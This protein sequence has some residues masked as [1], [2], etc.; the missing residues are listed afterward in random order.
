M[1][2]SKQEASRRARARRP[3]PR[4]TLISAVHPNP[5]VK[6]NHGATF[7]VTDQDGAVPLS[8]GDCGL[9]SHDTRYLSRHEVRLNGRR[10]QSVASVRLSFEHARWHLIADNVEAA[11]GDMRGARVAMTVDRVLDL[12]RMHE[13][14]ALRSYG[15]TSLT[16]LLEIALES[17]FADLFEVRRRTWQRRAELETTWTAAP[18]RLEFHYRHRDFVRRCVVRTLNDAAGITYANGSLRFPVDLRP[19]DEW[20]LCLQY[21]LLTHD[22]SMPQLDQRCPFDVAEDSSEEPVA[23]K[24]Q[25]SVARI[26]PADIRLQF[27]YER[28]IDDFAALR[29]HEQDSASDRWMPAAGLPWFMA[30]FGRDPLIASMQGMVVSPAVAIGTLENLARWQSDVDEPE[31]DA[32]PG[33]IPHELRVGEW[34]HFGIIPHRPYYGTADA[35]PLYLLLL[36]EHHRWVGDANELSAFKATAERCLDWIDRYGDRDG[37]GFQEY[38]P[39]A[40]NGYRNQAW[41][42]AHDGVLD[43]NGIF[44]ELPIGTCEMQAYVYAAKLHIA[45]LFEAWGDRDR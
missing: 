34:A 11:D 6:I 44:P 27:A 19:N 32:E 13:D 39:R 4:R 3:Q 18:N 40:P 29:L 25:M 5:T 22:G 24:W 21:D 17:D 41:R 10:P 33:K 45:P 14:F 36:A 16:L 38:A 8:A 23:E 35:T 26:D 9:F 37:D 2:S 15:R 30:L 42:D 20:K 7:L 12:H 1:T 43:E 31:R 28:A